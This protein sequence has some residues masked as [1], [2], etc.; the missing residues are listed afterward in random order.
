MKRA[1]MTRLRF[2]STTCKAPPLARRFAAFRVVVLAAMMVA[3]MAAPRAQAAQAGDDGAWHVC[4]QAVAQAERQHGIPHNLLQAVALAESGRWNERN[5]ARIAWPWTVYAEGRG[6]YLPSK[7]AALD[8]IERLRNKGV[9]NIDVGCMQIN[10]FHHG[11]EFDGLAQMLEPAANADYAA[12]F[13]KRLHE[14]SR[15]W[16]I[17][18]AHYHSRT[19]EHADRYR[20]RVLKLWPVAA[21]QVA[22]LGNKPAPVTADRPDTGQTRVPA[23]RVPASQHRPRQPRQ[24]SLRRPWRSAR[25]QCLRSGSSATPV[26]SQPHSLRPTAR[27]SRAASIEVRMGRRCGS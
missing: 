26:H 2:T 1:D 7:A 19:P 8:E 20:R 18:V 24:L 25:V 16:S 14:E 3:A 4:R 15:A 9:T 5:Q 10:L 11:A 12:R 13:L 21:R 23:R 6:R 27:Q 17:A 22:A